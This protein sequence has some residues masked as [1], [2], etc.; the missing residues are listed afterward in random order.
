MSDRLAMLGLGIVGD[1]PIDPEQPPLVDGVHL[2]WAPDQDAGF[3]WGG[4]YLFRRES[5]PSHSV[6]LRPQLERFR[7]GAT[8]STQIKTRAG[9]LSSSKPLVFTD[10]FAPAGVAEVDL[11]AQLSFDRPPGVTTK[12]ADIQIAFAAGDVTRTCVDFRQ[13]PLG[14]GPNPRS[15]NGAVFTIEPLLTPPTVESS[16]VEV[17]GGP[18]GLE[19]VSRFE[20]GRA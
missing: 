3:P 14:D 5:T 9:Q 12:R 8:Q 19:G 18:H 20:I 2:R 11:H 7:P 1:T 13:V 16:I 6:C 10:D 4:F 17:G 15:E